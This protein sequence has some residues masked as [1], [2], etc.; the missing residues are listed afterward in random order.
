M[1]HKYANMREPL[2]LSIHLKWKFET[3]VSIN[4]CVMRCESGRL[5]LI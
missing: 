1:T 5:F 3:G 2:E 4:G